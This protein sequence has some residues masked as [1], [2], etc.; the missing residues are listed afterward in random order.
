MSFADHTIVQLAR[1]IFSVIGNYVGAA[2]ELTV[3]EDN[4][5]VHLSDATTPGGRVFLNRDNSDTRYQARSTEL[6]GLLGFK[7]QDRGFLARL[8]PGSYRL[9]TWTFDEST[10]TLT[11]PN[12]FGGNPLL[13]LADD[14]T[15]DL[16]LSGVVTTTQQIIGTGGF[17]GDVEGNVVGNVIGNVTGNLTGNSTGTHTGAQIGDVDVRGRTLQLDAGQIHLA[18]LNDDV[19]TYIFNRAAPVGI[20]SMWAGLVADVPEN[21]ALCDGGNGTPDLRDRFIVGSTQTYAQGSTGGLATAN[22]GVTMDD[23]GAHNHEIT[24][25]NHSLTGTEIPPHVHGGGIGLGP[26][27]DQQVVVHGTKP[28]ISTAT[29]SSNTNVG[30]T[31]EQLTDSYGGFA[32]V[33]QGHSHVGTAAD[34]GLHSHTLHVTQGSILPPYYALA[35]IQKVA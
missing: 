7:D 14:I 33:V 6:D 1:D 27:T 35:Y 29:F 28:A 16:T 24:V 31:T 5:N 8:G 17:K 32:G 21:W 23:A 9:R 18:S 22:V 11:N 34:D 25:A 2:G 30:G 10:F 3:D 19:L 20:I 13:S 15:R 4:W 26:A 12:G